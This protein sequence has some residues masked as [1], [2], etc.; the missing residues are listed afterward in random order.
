MNIEDLYKKVDRLYKD[1]P[2][3]FL[4]INSKMIFDGDKVIDEYGY[5]Y[6]VF[7]SPI[8]ASW[9]LKDINDGTEKPFAFDTNSVYKSDKL[10]IYYK[11]SKARKKY[12]IFN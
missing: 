9:M 7:Y 1:M 5:K 4:D 10:K 6:I 8:K 11:N 12:K 3:G 2:T